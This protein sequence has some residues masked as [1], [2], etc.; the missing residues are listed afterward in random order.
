M[1]FPI[2]DLFGFQVVMVII[3]YLL[4]NHVCFFGIVCIF[5]KKVFDA[6]KM[7]KICAVLFLHVRLPIILQ[8][9]C[10]FGKMKYFWPP[11]WHPLKISCK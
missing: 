7:V 4:V 1:P 2:V 3:W 8:M 10:I 5:L 6:P 11:P 9:L